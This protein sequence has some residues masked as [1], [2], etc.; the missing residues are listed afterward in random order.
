MAQ[1]ISF[2]ELTGGSET[3]RCTTIDGKTYMSIRDII[4]VVCK[5][6]SKH[7]TKTWNRLDE[8]KKQEVETF[9]QS[10]QFPG[11][12]QTVQDVI[13]LKGALKLIEWLPGEPAKIYR[14]QVVE[15]LTRYLAGDSS[16]HAEIEAN[17]T[18]TAA[19][20]VLAR[21]EVGSKRVCDD[22]E[23]EALRRVKQTR[24][25]LD[26]VMEV[27][28]T[29]G[30]NMAQHK[31]DA[32]FMLDIYEKMYQAQQKMADAQ[33]HVEKTKQETFAVEMKTV[34]GK[35]VVEINLKEKLSQIEV[36][37][38]EKLDKLDAEQMEKLSLIEVVQK[39]KTGKLEAQHNDKELDHLEK[40][41]KILSD[42]RSAEL[43]FLQRKQELMQPQ[44]TEAMS[45]FTALFNEVV[46]QQVSKIQFALAAQHVA[47]QYHQT[48]KKQPEMRDKHHMY[49]NSCADNIKKWL[50]EWSPFF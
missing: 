10:F 20:H 7:A 16:M 43:L 9:C 35:A 29:L 41:T 5:Q 6:S 23:N 38:K 47:Q 34:A 50:L 25:A 13:T 18:S 45:S 36:D 46:N 8:E 42:E 26:E 17:A 2:A 30:S 33:S 11:Q 39:E 12:G 28:K 49:P 40:K 24:E 21:E 4:M 1:L 19:I 3:V 31:A 27:S 14:G 22:Q 37:Q 32:T 48:Y 44:A 15:I